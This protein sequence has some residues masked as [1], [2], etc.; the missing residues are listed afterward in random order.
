MSKP[1]VVGLVGAHRVG[2]TYL[3]E[4]LISLHPNLFH[5]LYSP[6]TRVLAAMKSNPS[7]A[8]VP[9][10]RRLLAQEGYML[11]VLDNLEEARR[12][13]GPCPV[14]LVDRTPYDVLGYLDVYFHAEIDRLQ[15]LTG[16]RV[17]GGEARTTP[18]DIKLA[19]QQYYVVQDMLLRLM[20]H[21]TQPDLT[22]MIH[23]HGEINGIVQ[24]QDTV[25]MVKGPMSNQWDIHT[26]ILNHVGKRPKMMPVL[27]LDD[28]VELRR[29]LEVVMDAIN[30]A[31]GVV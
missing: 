31:R 16:Q 10:D 23:P 6:G 15:K 14:V 7:N 20:Q 17:V 5:R 12:Y 9:F 28:G 4:E 30:A 13:T 21:H 29:R 24:H 2:K 26:S 19:T 27:H 3:V 25:A 8:D 18:E 11:G 1:L 22:I